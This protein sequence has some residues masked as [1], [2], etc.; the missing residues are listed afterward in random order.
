MIRFNALLLS[1]T[2]TGTAAVQ[3]II[4]SHPE[5][6]MADYEIQSVLYPLGLS[7]KPND[8]K[9]R[10]VFIHDAKVLRYWK[11][12]KS[13]LS[14][15]K[16]IYTVR[17]PIDQL[18]GMYNAAL[19]ESSLGLYQTP[20]IDLFFSKDSLIEI[21]KY[22]ADV[23]AYSEIL[24]KHFRHSMPV[25]FNTLKAERVK[26]TSKR[27]YDFL[28]TDS[29]YYNQNFEA[30]AFSDIVGFLSSTPIQIQLSDTN[31]VNIFLTF[32]K[33]APKCGFFNQGHAGKNYKCLGT[34]KI[35]EDRVRGLSGRVLFMWCD[36]FQIAVLHPTEVR[37]LQNIF[38]DLF[39][40]GINN[41]IKKALEIEAFC[42]AKKIQSLPDE[43]IPVVEEIIGERVRGFLKSH[44][45]IQWE[46]F[47]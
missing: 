6:Y 38:S 2:R 19:Y 37:V 10:V 31:V 32:D 16:F 14:L 43:F 26:E 33:V 17:N 28:E 7:I 9:S 25:E 5:V 34:L 47:L 21:F 40:I 20:E 29:T 12:I 39:D 3:N 42:N 24:S 44:P 30:P 23:L 1:L 45:E 4:S 46:H 13:S 41:W 18:V 15:D 36:S 27:I 22:S 11:Q 35:N 8:V